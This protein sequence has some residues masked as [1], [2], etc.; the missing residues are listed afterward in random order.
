[1]QGLTNDL[2]MLEQT[3]KGLLE[4]PLYNGFPNAV[5]KIAIARTINSVLLSFMYLYVLL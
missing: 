2:R 1:M 3:N 5:G 4:F